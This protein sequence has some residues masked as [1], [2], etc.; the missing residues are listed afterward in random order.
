ME[1]LKKKSTHTHTH[2]QANKSVKV[3]AANHGS[4]SATRGMR[5][6]DGKNSEKKKLDVCLS[7]FL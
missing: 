2:T 5:G 7:L 1:K 6:K 4:S 3:N